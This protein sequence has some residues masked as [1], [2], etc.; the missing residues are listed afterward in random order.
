MFWASHY[1]HPIS[2]AFRVPGTPITAPVSRAFCP[3]VDFLVPV[4][5]GVFSCWDGVPYRH[6]FAPCPERPMPGR[7]LCLSR[8]WGPN[9]SSGASK[10]AVGRLPR[11]SPPAGPPQAVWHASFVSVRGDR[12]V[13]HLPSAIPQSVITS[14]KSRILNR[15]TTWRRG[16]DSSTVVFATPCECPSYEISPPLSRICGFRLV[17]RGCARF[18]LSVPWRGHNLVTRVIPSAG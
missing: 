13:R 14:P 6:P 1:R 12:P 16:R 5:V 4:V 2:L 7:A 8:P 17:S 9:Q 3:G 15:K 11:Q 18:R 10:T